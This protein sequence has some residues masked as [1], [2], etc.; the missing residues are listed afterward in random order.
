MTETSPGEMDCGNVSASVTYKRRIG[1]PG[2]AAKSMP[3]CPPS[4]VPIQSTQSTSI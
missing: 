4:D 2:C 1:V 3:I